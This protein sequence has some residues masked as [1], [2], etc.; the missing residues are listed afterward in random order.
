MLSKC[1]FMTVDMYNNQ[2]RHWKRC[3]LCGHCQDYIVSMDEKS[4]S[5]GIELSGER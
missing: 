3:F 5:A 4:W 1:L 2:R